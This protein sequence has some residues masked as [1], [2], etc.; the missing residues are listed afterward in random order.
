MTGQHRQPKFKITLHQE[1][2]GSCLHPLRQYVNESK[3]GSKGSFER[4]VTLHC[5]PP[6]LTLRSPKC[7]KCTVNAL[8]HNQQQHLFTFPFTQKLVKLPFKKTCFMRT[9][10]VWEDQIK[11]SS[12][13]IPFTC[14]T[15]F[16]DFLFF[17]FFFFFCKW[18]TS[19]LPHSPD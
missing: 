7:Q 15:K 17:S 8:F 9:F 13:V 14:L 4:V 5:T 16:L 10:S 2:M 3:G 19:Y 18:Q 6:P 11:L 1:P 12:E